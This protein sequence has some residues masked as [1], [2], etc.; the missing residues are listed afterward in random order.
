MQIYRKLNLHY[1]KIKLSTM[2]KFLSVIYCATQFLVIYSLS[3][4]KCGKSLLNTFFFL[5]FKSLGA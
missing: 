3:F 5:I 2:H 4:S 1:L